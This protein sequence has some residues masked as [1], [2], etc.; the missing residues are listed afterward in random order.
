MDRALA[1]LLLVAVAAAA[2]SP[3]LSAV[4]QLRH[5]C[6]TGTTDDTASAPA[7]EESPMAMPAWA[8][9]A[10]TME[11]R[12]GPTPPLELQCVEGE[13][14]QIDEAV[15]GRPSG[16]C[17][18]AAFFKPTR[19]E[20]IRLG[21][22]Y[23]RVTD[24]AVCA[25][26]DVRDTLSARCVG[27][28]SCRVTLDAL[29]GAENSYRGLCFGDLLRVGVRFR[30]GAAGNDNRGAENAH[31]VAHRDT[32]Y[33]DV[34]DTVALMA[35][36][37]EDA[38]ATRGYRIAELTFAT[39]A[40][41]GWPYACGF[42]YEADFAELRCHDDDGSAEED[43]DADAF[44]DFDMSVAA[45]RKT[46]RRTRVIKDVPVAQYGNFNGACSARLNPKV[47][48]TLPEMVCGEDIKADVAA[49]CLGRSSCR[50]YVPTAGTGDPCPGR[51]K[52]AIIIA[53]CG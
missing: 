38:A 25:G 8:G 35:Q 48:A 6:V 44:D 29:L 53:R 46:G 51:K 47:A 37:A 17:D 49:Q 24:D 30:C 10:E 1:L 16:R 19:E 7:A 39:A 52:A 26:L 3:L 11:R 18:A 50:V 14:S 2:A 12:S 33:F 9:C 27:H 4:P 40:T 13:I 28:A 42:G 31:G 20:A 36:R 45:P 22:G 41:D 15:L 21:V 32:P 34:E 5:M 43:L 23:S